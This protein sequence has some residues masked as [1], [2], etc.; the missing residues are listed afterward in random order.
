MTSGEQPRAPTLSICMATFK[1]GAFIRETLD[2]ILPQLTPEVELLVVD[3]AS[4]DDTAE[5]MADY[6][7]R[8]PQVRYI[9]EE[10]NGGVDQDYDK[11]VG[12]ATGRYCW[13]MTDDDLLAQDAVAK[14]LA[15]LAAP[16]VDLV[17]VN[18]EVRNADFS[19]LLT[20]RFMCF[21]GDRNYGAAEAGRLLAETG[22]YLTFIGAVVVRRSLWLSRRREQLYGSLFIHVG[23]IFQ[24]P[25]ENTVAIAEPLIAIRYGNAMWTSR[26][27]EVWMFKWPSLVWS[28][29]QLPEQAKAAVTPRE[30]WRRLRKLGLYRAFGAYSL[31]EYERFL[32]PLLAGRARLAPWLIAACPRYLASFAS[33]CYCLLFNRNPVTAFDLSRAPRAAWTSR[34]AARS[35]GL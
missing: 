27:F 17:L 20:P 19:T 23:V 33:G 12:Y 15:R 1:R 16:A 35:L 32:K 34:L 4:P 24:A 2:S 7:A 22:G 10:R 25:V 21:D 5:V 13:L 11:A 14:V 26:T 30:P 3:G 31:A 29:E 8:H 6:V 18:A 9:R 28:F